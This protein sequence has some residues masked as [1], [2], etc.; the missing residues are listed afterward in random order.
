M[1]RDEF[2]ATFRAQLVLPEQRLIFDYWLEKAAGRSMP[3]KNDICPTEIPRHLPLVSLIE[4]ETEPMNFKFRLA[5]TRTR[6]IYQQEVTGMRM[7]EFTEAQ[8]R[9]Y[10]L[11]AHERIANTGRPAQGILRGPEQSRDHLVQYW[12]RLPLAVD[13][14]GPKL[15]F[16]F[17][18]CIPVSLANNAQNIIEDTIANSA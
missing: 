3:D 14:I 8:N 13:G 16:G 7:T 6:D 11:S 10:W 15:I 1:S 17:D 2:Y 9:D 4:I 12:I 18:K 5:G